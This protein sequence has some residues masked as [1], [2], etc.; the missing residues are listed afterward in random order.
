[1]PR[2]CKH[3]IVAFEI[4]STQAG[5]IGQNDRGREYTNHR[6]QEFSSHFTQIVYF[7]I[8]FRV[9]IIPYPGHFGRCHRLEWIFLK[10]HD[11]MLA[12]TRH[13]SFVVPLLPNLFGWPTPQQ[14]RRWL[15]N[16]SQS[17][18]ISAVR[19]CLICGKHITCEV[20]RGY[21]ARDSA[22]F[23]FN[24]Y[25]IISCRFSCLWYKKRPLLYWVKS[26]K[27]WKYRLR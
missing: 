17:L 23:T 15:C 26:F 10:G 3:R 1:M 24:Y 8:T 18:F 13:A 21:R 9:T 5:D 25:T 12:G 14:P 6:N 7:Y 27:F 19:F 20:S 16:F 22:C 2:P 4:K 11:A